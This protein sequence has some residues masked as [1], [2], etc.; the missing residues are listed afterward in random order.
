MDRI[1]R[2]E[3][4]RARRL[5]ERCQPRLEPRNRASSLGHPCERLLTYRR[6]ADHYLHAAP[7][8]LDRASVYHEG[9]VH[10]RA[11]VQ[12]MLADGFDVL[13]TQ[14]PFEYEGIGG[15]IDGALPAEKDGQPEPFD[16]KSMADRAFRS[17]PTVWDGPVLYGDLAYFANADAK[18]WWLRQYPA[19][20]EIYLLMSGCPRG[21]FIV[22]NKTT[23]MRAWVLVVLD[24]PAFGRCQGLLDKSRRIDG[25][26][27]RGEVPERTSD[28]TLCT[29]CD[30]RLHC[31]P[32]CLEPGRIALLDDGYAARLTALY[33]DLAA[34]KATIKEED[35]CKAVAKAALP[36]G[37][38]A[39]AGNWTIIVDK[40][41]KQTRV[42]FMPLAEE[43]ASTEDTED[44]E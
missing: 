42:K 6:L 28:G 27:E 17:M 23:G 30:M 8:P 4:M 21:W 26:V 34:A 9:T 19:Q 35:G 3:D 25:Y 36:D 43:K 13:W 14:R 20:M 39:V 31:A 15:T 16:A 7:T 33:A 41:A 10:E 29:W 40:G 18:H 32:P 1:A 22:K 37:G 11:I 12:E 38:V 24:D 44:D 2:I 5:L